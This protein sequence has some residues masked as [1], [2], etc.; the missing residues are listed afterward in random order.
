MMKK[1]D[2]TIQL[3]YT[4]PREVAGKNPLT[5]KHYVIGQ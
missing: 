5:N 2:E 4:L 1:F 3:L